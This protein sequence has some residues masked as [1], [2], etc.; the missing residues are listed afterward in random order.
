MVVI[1]P[2][3]DDRR[4][5]PLEKTGELLEAAPGFQ[6]VISYNPGY[7]HGLKDLAEHPSA[8]RG[9]GVR[10]PAPISKRKSSRTKRASTEARRWRSS[11]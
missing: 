11:R 3:T 9:A 7:Q 10:L 4:I 1:H 8:I 6:L 2:L 5:L